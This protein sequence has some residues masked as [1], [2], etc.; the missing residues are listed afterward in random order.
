V[1]YEIHP[2]TPP[3]GIRLE[4]IFGAGYRDRQ[5]GIASRC[6]ELGLPFKPPEILSNTRL[7]VEAAVFAREAGQ[8]PVFHRAVLTAYFARGLDIGKADVL[9]TLADEAGLYASELAEALQTGQYSGRR[10]EAEEEAR[11]VG[12]RGVP[13]FF[14]GSGAR[15]V[16]A[17]DLDHFRRVLEAI[18]A[19]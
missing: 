10:V 19:A 3:D 5:Q 9:C 16:G 2:E 13:T 6:R 8:H 12:V 17:Q 1:S 11:R 18:P 7:A 15:V 4:Q 14:F